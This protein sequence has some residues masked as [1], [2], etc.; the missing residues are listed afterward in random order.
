MEIPALRRLCCLASLKRRW[1]AAD[2]AQM[3]ET[4]HVIGA[5]A[6]PGPMSAGSSPREELEQQL[7]WLAPEH[8]AAPADALARIR[9]LC[10]RHADLHGAM[11]A[12]QATHQAL[13]RE[14]L[15]AAV[16]Q[17]R[18]DTDALSQEDVAG[19]FTALWNGG[20]QGFD[21][22]LRT[23]KTGERRPMAMPWV[24]D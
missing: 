10:E 8:R 22:V 17:F 1:P 4:N 9:F 18:R 23:R 3:T 12:V 7:D 6:T 20:K 13:P 24:K 19:L 15:A 11:L 21:T 14:I 16:R 5:F 2:T